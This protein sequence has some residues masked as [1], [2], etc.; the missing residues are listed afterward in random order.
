MMA[1][2]M[3]ASAHRGADHPIGTGPFTFRSWTPG[4]SFVTS[5]N[6]SY[7]QSGKPYLSSLTFK[8]L[9]DS[10]TQQAALQSGDIDMALTTSPKVADTLEGQGFT[11]VKD[12]G[13]EAGAALANTLPT[14]NG[15]PNPLANVHARLALAY[16]TNRPAL[17]AIAG[18]A[19]R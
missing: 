6:P 9:A 10:S 14:V 11:V 3:L 17:A 18:R 13:S 19:Y 4:A 15:K 7:W 8:V 5:R 2:G 12:W 16:A 1:P